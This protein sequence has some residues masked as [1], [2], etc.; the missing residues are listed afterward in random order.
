M[1]KDR[2]PAFERRL[3]E[4]RQEA[5]K[6]GRVQGRGVDIAGSPLPVAALRNGANGHGKNGPGRNGHGGSDPE[7]AVQSGADKPGYFGMPALK[8]P[9]W[10]WEI[11]LYFF[12]GGLT[13]MTAVV[14]IAATLFGQPEVVR[15]AMW[16]AAFGGVASPI[17]LIMD[18]GRPLLFFNMLRVFKLR[19]PMSMGVYILTPYGITSI[20]GAMAVELAHWDL[21]P[22][23]LPTT[24]LHLVAVGL[25]FAAG[26]SGMLLATYTG[27]LIGA[28]AVPA[29]NQHRALLPVHF[30]T[31]GLGSGVS[32]LHLLGYT[33]RPLAAIFWVTAVVETVLW[34]WLL[35]RRHGKIDRALHE[36][37][38][39]NL[40]LPAEL[41]NGPIAVALLAL[42]FSRTAAVGFLL[43][44]LLSRFGWVQAGKASAR[45][46]EAA[47]ASQR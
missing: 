11:P 37:L 29:W 33:L 25:T 12:V 14:A 45:D 26:L 15:A 4:L 8:P 31:A 35:F 10:T 42:G 40:L 36:G 32:L 5:K 3:D 27:V 22:P 24:L 34:L 2:D 41:L 23:G 28:T 18:L 6:Q 44:S 9:V 17:L 47:F 1:P 46:P 13:G 39:G 7:R 38:G 30:G 21:L 16:I 43:G 19:S 20:P